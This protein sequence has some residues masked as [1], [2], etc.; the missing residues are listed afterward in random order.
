M[1]RL[2]RP[3]F[4]AHNDK[5]ESIGTLTTLPA[6][7]L[8]LVVCTTIPILISTTIISIV[9]TSIFGTALLV[10]F[11]VPVTRDDEQHRRRQ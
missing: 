6:T 5:H 3:T 9:R 2:M 4:D 8:K 7:K 11:L 10:A 1:I